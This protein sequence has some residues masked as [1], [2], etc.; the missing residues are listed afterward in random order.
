[1]AACRATAGASPQRQSVE[2]PVE[3]RIGHPRVRFERSRHC[4]RHA[5]LAELIAESSETSEEDVV[6]TVE[7]AAT[8]HPP[9][10]R[11]AQD[12]E[13]PHRALG[14]ATGADLF[15]GVMNR[16]ARMVD[17]LSARTTLLQREQD[18]RCT[19]L[20]DPCIPAPHATALL[21]RQRVHLLV[22]RDERIHCL[23]LGAHH[24]AE[25]RDRL[26]VHRCQLARAR[27][28]VATARQAFAGICRSADSARCDITIRRTHRRAG[29]A[30]LGRIA[31]RDRLSTLDLRRGS[32]AQRG[33]RA[34]ARSTARHAARLTVIRAATTGAL[35]TD[36]IDTEPGCTRR[37]AAAAV[38]AVAQHAHQKHPSDGRARTGDTRASG[39]PVR[40]HGEL[41]IRRDSGSEL[42]G[43]ARNV[44]RTI[45][46]ELAAAR[47]RRAR[48][49]HPCARARRRH[50]TLRDA[51]QLRDSAEPHRLH[52]IQA[53][54]GHAAPDARYPDI[55]R[56]HRDRAS[57]ARIPCNRSN[58]DRSAPVGPVVR[59]HVR[60]PTARSRRRTDRQ[61][62][63]VQGQRRAEVAG[64]RGRR[65][66]RLRLPTAIAR[67]ERPHGAAGVAAHRDAPARD[68]DATTEPAHS[69]RSLEEHEPVRHIG[70]RGRDGLTGRSFRRR[71]PSRQIDDP[72][73]A[74]SASRP[75]RAHDEQ[76]ALERHGVPELIAR[77]DPA[78][79]RECD[80]GA[81]T[82]NPPRI[83]LIEM[84]EASGLRGPKLEPRIADGDAT[85]ADGHGGA[86]RRAIAACHCGR[87]HLAD[88]CDQRIDCHR[89]HGI[90]RVDIDA[91]MIGARAHHG[92]QRA[93]RR[94]ERVKCAVAHHVLIVG[95]PDLRIR[96]SEHSRPALERHFDVDRRARCA[97]V[98]QHPRLL[99]PIRHDVEALDPA[100]VLPFDALRILRRQARDVAVQPLDARR[101]QQ[102]RRLVLADRTQRDRAVTHL[103]HRRSVDH[104]E[105]AADGLER[106][107]SVRAEIRRARVA[108]RDCAR[109]GLT[110]RRSCRTP[111]DERRDARDDARCSSSPLDPLH[112]SRS[113]ES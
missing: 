79:A 69:D 84:D 105:A 25:S 64:A 32:R 74:A 47:A 5:E 102:Q 91:Q 1:M 28:T 15:R 58:P 59:E 53:H 70:A 72:H 107:T 37:C 95:E 80:A 101:S 33:A 52:A 62:T 23:V 41:A 77:N 14:L 7:R 4:V 78:A 43:R 36:T 112:C 45:S 96:R 22:E 61:D 99:E 110:R 20:E 88:D 12:A 48:D 93:P 27:R 26:V 34:I 19:A 2:L 63:V 75:R 83:S 55:A 13:C 46:E 106:T 39:R 94:V 38:T 103:Q 42:H 29:H 111:A 109:V 86:E 76:V 3:L 89:V 35:A 54:H 6:A 60:T 57:S 17:F 97:L 65:E 8:R 16:R 40:H 81:F 30:H 18:E 104:R 71:E 90:T 98:S 87:E 10:G 11:H 67:R 68:R 21:A 92:G 66:R 31:R 108:A 113:F 85:R 82:Q 56:R 50:G 9:I 100:A 24:F 73:T 49:H 44:H 51:T